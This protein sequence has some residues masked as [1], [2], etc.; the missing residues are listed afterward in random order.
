V[1]PRAEAAMLAAFAS[2]SAAIRDGLAGHLLA[3]GR[4]AGNAPAGDGEAGKVRE[5]AALLLRN[6]DRDA[7]AAS[8]A[9]AEQRRWIR[10]AEAAIGLRL[11]EQG[12]SIETEVPGPHG[13]TCDFLADRNG[14]RLAIHIKLLG[15]GGVPPQGGSALGG[16]ERALERLERPFLVEVR[17]RPG[18]PDEAR[19]ELA[20]HLR[21]FILQGRVGEEQAWRDRRGGMLGE[22]RILGVHEGDRVRLLKDPEGGFDRRV[23]RV[24]RLMRKAYGQ[25]LPGV[26]N[27]VLFA[28][29][30]RRL[31]LEVERAMLGSS[32]ERWDLHPPQGERIAHG[33]ADDGFWQGG[34][35]AE[36]S[37]VGWFDFL[38]PRAVGRWWSR[39]ERPVDAAVARFL[40]ALVGSR[41]DA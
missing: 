12:A 33:R 14:V 37:L 16:R 41:R 39:P 9:V 17:T 27:V 13:R 40:D 11:L 35:A 34:R 21:R 3:G 6:L 24:R 10:L 2:R 31:D 5:A 28:V 4:R 32:V 15:F 1:P 8:T 26:P 38:E 36:S 30:G 7:S 22:A 29:G 25:F 18:L 19:A 23:E 20:M